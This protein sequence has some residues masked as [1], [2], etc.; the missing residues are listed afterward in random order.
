MDGH[1][2]RWLLLCVMFAFAPSSNAQVAASD[3]ETAGL[4]AEQAGQLRE[5]FDDYVA[6]LQA[7]PDPPPAETDWRLRQRIIK[8]AL[9]L[10]PP[11]AVPEEAQQGLSR[12]QTAIK[13]AKTQEEFVA[14]VSEFRRALR[15]APW[16][17]S[18]YFDFGQLLEDAKLYQSAALSFELYLLAAPAAQDAESVRKRINDLLGRF[19][20]M[21]QYAHHFGSGGDFVTGDLIVSNGSIRFGDSFAFPVSD[22]RSVERKPGP[23]FLHSFRA[24]HIQ[25][26]NGK[27]FVLLPIG[28]GDEG[29]VAI[30]KAIKDMDPEHRI[31]FK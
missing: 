24:L 16:L 15:L 30:E 13:S 5:A 4:A 20:A 18:G 25:L 21:Y 10:D 28:L 17:A 14:A 19:P 23:M 3:R 8:L 2:S 22:V 1:R 9:K 27:K 7:L 12:G 26:K 6:A 31:V 29:V 11:P